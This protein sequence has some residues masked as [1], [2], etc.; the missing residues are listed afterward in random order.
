[1]TIQI[2]AISPRRHLG[3]LALLHAR[4]VPLLRRTPKRR[5]P[6]SVHDMSDYL[7]RDIGLP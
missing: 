3:L 6:S 4:L 7:R 5:R 2:D 1:M